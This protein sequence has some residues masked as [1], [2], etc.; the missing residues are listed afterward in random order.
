MT[1]FALRAARVF[2]GTHFLARHAVVIKDGVIRDGLPQDRLDPSIPLRDL[3]NHLLAPGFI[4]LQ[5]NGGGGALL[6]DAPSVAVVQR[7]R[8]Q[9]TDACWTMRKVAKNNPATSIRYL[10]VSPKSILSARPNMRGMG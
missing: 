2:N 8:P 9:N 3:G 1:G 4:D 5:V 6:N 10:A 7:I